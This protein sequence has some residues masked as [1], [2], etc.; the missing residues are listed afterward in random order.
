PAGARR[1]DPGARPEDPRRGPALPR[2][3]PVHRPDTRPRRR[4]RRSVRGKAGVLNGIP[5]G[6]LMS[7]TNGSRGVNG[8]RRLLLSIVIA[9]FATVSI[10]Y[11]AWW[12]VSGRYHE[13]TDDAYVGGNLVQVTPQV[14][15]TVLAI[16]ADDTDF[17]STG[18]TLV[19][20]DKADSR[21]A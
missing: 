14:A 21:V 16:H 15:G 2:A 9:A 12:A 10:A 8:R 1:G 4:L 13:S 5:Q 17:V 7:K 6:T 19:E 20:L 18:Q 11:G 3:R